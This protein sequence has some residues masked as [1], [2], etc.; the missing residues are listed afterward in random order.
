MDFEFS[1]EEKKLLAEVRAFIQ[2]EATPELEKE[3]A[4]LGLIYGG[5]L[6]REFI[7][8][9]AAK[10]WLTLHW[11]EEYGGLG[12]SAVLNFAVR[13]EMAYARV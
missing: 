4:E 11:P 3:S 8:K 7:R 13:E 6:G 9:F 5:Q 2:E 1:Q 10:G 12:K